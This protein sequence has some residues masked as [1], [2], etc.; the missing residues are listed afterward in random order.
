MADR[1]EIVSLGSGGDGLAQGPDGPVHVPFA[2]PGEIVSAEREGPR[3][4]LVALERASPD[5]IEPF[6][7]YF[8]R[9]G[10]CVAQH[11]APDP[12]AAWKRGKLVAA[13]EREGGATAVG[14]LVD[15][16]GEGRR[17]V[18]FHARRV[19]D[20]T[21]VGFMEAKSHRL[22]PIE[23]CPITV[24]ALAD[25]P[26]IAAGLARALSGTGKPLDIAVTA[27]EGGLDVDLRGQGPLG[28]ARRQ[29]LIGLAGQLDL[30]RLSVHGEILIERRAP[31]ILV[32]RARVLPP[33]GSFLQATAAG[34]AA[35]AAAVRE[36][37]GPAKRV[38][39][40]FA[41]I[42]PLTLRL[43]ERADVHAVETEAAMLAALDRAARETAGL[44]RVTTETRDL[45]RRPLF[46][47]EL[48]RFDALVLDP[49]RQGAEAQIRQV[50]PSSLDR[51][52]LVSCDTGTFARDAKTLVS[53][54][55]TLERVVPVDQFKWSQHLEVVGLFRRP[56]AGAGRRRR[57]PHG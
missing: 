6:C 42:G 22:V 12:Y 3:A 43:A 21:A 19:D 26:R 35:L 46:P 11:V 33:P 10:G 37:I 18:V 28:E 15:G 1:L 39:D 27:T 9:C 23:T 48:D 17:R 52:V 53:G 54:G 45:F 36:G 49:P 24:P 16:H 7:P 38:V 5:R 40:L 44:R 50:I 29:A 34:E 41:G 57:S 32:G 13:L 8:G 56:R 25:S 31:T 2:L 14:P 4:R 51:V 30:A 55:F 20:I 47:G